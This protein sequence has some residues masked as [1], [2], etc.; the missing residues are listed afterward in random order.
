VQYADV[1]PTLLDLV[2]ATTTHTFDGTSFA[3]VLRGE[4]ATHRD[5]A[6][7]AHNNIPE[8]PA[9]PIR[10]ITDGEWRYISN[11]TPDE[12]FIEKHLMGLLGGSAAHNPYWSS[13]MATALDNPHTYKLVKRYIHRPAEQLYHTAADPA[14]MTNLADKPEHA[15][16][17]AKLSNALDQWLNQQGD[18]GIPQDTH[19]AHKAGKQGKHLHFPKP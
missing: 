5:Y 14:E 2:G 12:I 18:P 13:W 3:A 7:A 17:K 1:T 19:E 6:Y 9:Y 11:L 8:G 10:S 16:I 15:A 4:K